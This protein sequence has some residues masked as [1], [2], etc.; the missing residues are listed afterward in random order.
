MSV[1]SL[2]VAE[3]NPVTSEAVDK[4]CVELGVELKQDEREDYR[5][6]L[7]VF[8]E[9]SEQVMSMPGRL[10]YPLK[11]PALEAERIS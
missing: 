1:F 4:L 8:H 6:L 11:Y 3:D 5:R 7:A 10:P 2:T 9:T